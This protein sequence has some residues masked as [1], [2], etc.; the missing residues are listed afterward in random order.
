VQAAVNAY[1]DGAHGPAPSLV[2][3][4]KAVATA[5]YLLYEVYPGPSDHDSEALSAVIHRDG[6]GRFEVRFL[7]RKRT[8]DVVRYED[9]EDSET[10]LYHKSDDFEDDAEEESESKEDDE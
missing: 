8:R 7:E 3:V 1:A 5:C 4:I 10:E 2:K 6:H 9:E